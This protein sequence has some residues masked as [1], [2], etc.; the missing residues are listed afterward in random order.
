MKLINEK[1][2]HILDAETEKLLTKRRTRYQHHQMYTVCLAD[3]VFEDAIDKDGNAHPL[4]QGTFIKYL[5]SDDRKLR[6]SAFRNVYKAY[7]AHNNTLG[8]TLAGE[9]KKNVFNARTHN[10]RKSIE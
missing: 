9:V 8:A 1:R 6:E 5:E 2:P 10:T 7:G 3:L 4:T